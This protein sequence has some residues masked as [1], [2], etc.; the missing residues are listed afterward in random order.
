M[1][2]DETREFTPIGIAIVTVSDTR[3]PATDTSGDLLEAR[4]VREV[5]G[6]RP[7]PPPSSR[8]APSGHRVAAPCRR[9]SSLIALCKRS[10]ANSVV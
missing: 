2:I 1:P 7:T 4:V 5:L 8:P 10:A 6:D 3:E 9:S